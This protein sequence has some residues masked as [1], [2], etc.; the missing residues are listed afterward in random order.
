M[1]ESTIFRTI[2]NWSLTAVLGSALTLCPLAA[3]AVG[4]SIGAG[5][6]VNLDVG[7]IDLGCGDLVI[8]GNLNL[9]SGTYDNV[10]AVVINSG[11]MLNGNSGTINLSGGWSNNGGTTNPGNSQVTFGTDCG[12]NTI[13]VSGNSSFSSMT[14]QTNNGRQITFEAGSTTSVLDNLIMNG[15]GDEN[16]SANLLKVRSSSPGN[17][18]FLMVEGN[19]AINKVDVQDNHASLPG[20]WIN[21]GL[22]ENFD[23]IDGP[24]NLRWF[25]SG[26][27]AVNSVPIPT[28]SEWTLALLAL[29]MLGMGMFR[30]RRLV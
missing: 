22:A 17:P 19:Y 4:L 14:V 28:L 21:L 24:G 20:E 13:S 16:N 6:T 7:T 23:S 3:Q 1:T 2:K 27:A 12:A 29:L 26:V 15:A 10:S 9:D 5:G 25:Q 11:G 8:D 30:T 18:A